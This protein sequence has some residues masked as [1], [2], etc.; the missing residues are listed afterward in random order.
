MRGSCMEK[1]VVSFVCDTKIN[2]RQKKSIDNTCVVF[3]ITAVCN[4]TCYTRLNFV[5]FLNSQ[6]IP[7]PLGCMFP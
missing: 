7:C 2:G 3:R 1:S 5:E 4:V 6:Q